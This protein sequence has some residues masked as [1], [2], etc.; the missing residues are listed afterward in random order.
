MLEDV[1]EAYLNAL[2]RAVFAFARLEARAVETC[3][4]IDPGSMRSL[5]GRT[6]GNVADRLCNL[7]ETMEPSR[8]TSELLATARTF[9]RLV[10]LRNAIVHAKPGRD[11]EG[12]AILVHEGDPWMRAEFDEA[13]RQFDDCAARLAALLDGFLDEP[14]PGEPEVAADFD[15]IDRDELFDRPRRE[16]RRR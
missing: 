9:S 5:A 2:G 4:R 6:A 8:D 7:A 15:P 3:E 14:A 16:R 11:E 10:R 12:G 1:G 13:S